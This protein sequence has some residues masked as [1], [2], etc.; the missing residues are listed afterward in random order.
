MVKSGIFPD[1]ERKTRVK[2]GIFP[3]LDAKT[4]VKSGIFPDLAEG[5]AEGDKSGGSEEKPQKFVF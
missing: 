3:D 2:S 1:L 4:R 5:R